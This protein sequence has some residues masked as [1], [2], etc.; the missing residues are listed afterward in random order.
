M[1]QQE[2][3]DSDIHVGLEQVHRGGVAQSVGRDTPAAQRGTIGNR[4][5]DG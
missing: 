5:A 1:A 2:R 3:N 4:S